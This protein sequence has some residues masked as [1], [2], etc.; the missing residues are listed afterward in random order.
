MTF[1]I[2]ASL[3]YLHLSYVDLRKAIDWLQVTFKH[4]SFLE[5]HLSA[6]SLED[7]PSPISVNSTKSLVV[8]DLS[9]NQLSSLR[10]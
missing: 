4:P 6:C 7:D 1:L 9:R 10:K 3:H 2:L 5:L 8:L